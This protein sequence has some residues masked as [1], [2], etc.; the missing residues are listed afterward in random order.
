MARAARAAWMLVIAAIL[1]PTAHVSAQGLTIAAAS[2]LQGVLP[3]VTAQ[4]ERSTGHSVRV[5]F[6]SSGNFFAQIQHG[7]PFDV[8]L[9]ADIDYPRRLEQAGLAEPGTLYEYATGEIVLW[10]LE[11]GGPNLSAGL[12]SLLDPSVR[13]IAIANPEH[14]PYGRAAVA[15]LRSAGIYDRVRS[16]LVMGENISQAAQFV[17]SGNAEAGIIARAI[18]LMPGLV[19]LGHATAIPTDAYPP[20]RQA[21]IVTSGSRNKET[22]SR[23]LAFLKTPAIRQLMERFGFHVAS[24]R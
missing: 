9:S 14:A 17:H 6:G 19:D 8:F 3:L 18:V 16:K 13:R 24:T 4:F 15:A 21:A 22:A 2:D 12:Q 23:F 5:T 10:A 20:I 1:W 11:K 7:A